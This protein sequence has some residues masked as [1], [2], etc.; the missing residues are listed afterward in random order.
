VQ[1]ARPSARTR[2]VAKETKQ[3]DTLNI[4]SR[5]WVRGLRLPLLVVALWVAGCGGGGGGGG[6]PPGPEPF[7]TTAAT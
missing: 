2:D 3:M 1:A 7:A 5:A 4:K 6:T